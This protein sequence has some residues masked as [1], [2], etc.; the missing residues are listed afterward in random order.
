MGEQVQQELLEQEVVLEPKGEQ[1]QKEELV[2]WEEQARW[3]DQ[4]CLSQQQKRLPLPP[5]AFWPRPVFQT[6]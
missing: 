2:H 1:V 3:E 6:M 4:L 5:V